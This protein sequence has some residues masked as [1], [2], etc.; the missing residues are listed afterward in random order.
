MATPVRHHS[1][2]ALRRRGSAG[3]RLRGLVALFFGA[4]VVTSAATVS[5]TVSQRSLSLIL[6]EAIS[7]GS[8]LTYALKGVDVV[9]LAASAAG[10]TSGGAVEMAPVLGAA[11]TALTLGNW[12]YVVEVKEASAGSVGS[13]TFKVEL[14]QNGAS[15]GALYM[16]QA[17]A[18]AATVEG[19]TFSWDIGNDLGSNTGYKVEVTSV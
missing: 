11:N 17:T 10:D 19:V 16:K 14:F 6:G 4:L 13:G 15:K 7:L 12:K 3:L 2:F 1:E 8:S 9:A 18:D 5:V